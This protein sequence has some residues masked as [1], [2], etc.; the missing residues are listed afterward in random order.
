MTELTTEE[1]IEH[2]SNKDIK[3]LLQK[4]SNLYET[5]NISCELISFLASKI[6]TKTLDQASQDQMKLLLQRL[7]D[8]HIKTDPAIEEKLTCLFK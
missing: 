8:A 7:R 2:E 4:R 5:I 3:A 6:D 1:M